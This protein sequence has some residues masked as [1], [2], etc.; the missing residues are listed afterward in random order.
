ME[1]S[2]LDLDVD[3]DSEEIDNV[4]TNTVIYQN[5]F[6]FMRNQQNTFISR[7]NDI[8]INT[9]IL[10]PGSPI[11]IVLRNNIKQKYQ[12]DSS[13]NKNIVIHKKQD[14]SFNN[15]DCCCCMD[16]NKKLS[17]RAYRSCKAKPKHTI[18]ND[19][20]QKSNKRECFY[21]F[22]YGKNTNI[23]REQVSPNNRIFTIQE[24]THMR[25]NHR[26]RNTSDQ[27]STNICFVLFCFFFLWV[28]LTII[29]LL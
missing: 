13:S 5:N 9:F 29:S 26:R 21:C 4:V 18:C 19:C 17:F 10:S 1:N 11:N 8:S 16:S 2:V 6:G 27:I 7:F 25:Q 28:I 3:L 12:V 24:L 15:I 23:R 22:P 14:P 20:F